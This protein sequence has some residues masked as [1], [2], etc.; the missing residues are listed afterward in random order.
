MRKIPAVFFA[1]LLAWPAALPAGEPVSANRNTKAQNPATALLTAAK[2]ASAGAGAVNLAPGTK[3]DA[4]WNKAIW[5]EPA[6]A[7]TADNIYRLAGAQNVGGGGAAGP[8]QGAGLK[9]DYPTTAVNLRGS[10]DVNLIGARHGGRV[11]ASGAGPIS[12]DGAIVVPAA[13]DNLALAVIDGSMSVRSKVSGSG[14]VNITASVPGPFLFV[15]D[16]S[17]FTGTF[18]LLP[19]ST[20]VDYQV[21]FTSSAPEGRLGIAPS[22]ANKGRA[23][24]QLKGNLR[25]AVVALPRA[26]GGVLYLP[27]G[28]YRY[29]DLAIAGADLACLADGG[30]EIEVLGMETGLAKRTALLLQGTT[31]NTLSLAGEWRFAL[32]AADAGIAEKWH[33][34]ALVD[35]IRLP[36]VLQSQ[37]FGHAISKTMPW[38]TNL[39]DPHWF[40]REMFK[41]HA[42]EGKVKIPYFSQPPRHY[43]G[44]AWYQRDIEIPPAWTGRSV[45]L[46]LELPHWQTDLWLDDQPVGFNKGLQAPHLYDLGMIPPGRH[47]LTV[48]VDNRRIFPLG[49]DSHSVSDQLGGTWNG[50]VGRIELQAVAACHFDTVNVHPH[51]AEKFVRVTAVLGNSSGLAGRG[52]LRAEATLRGAATPTAAKTVEVAWTRNGGSVEFDLPLGPDA[53]LWDEFNPNLY[54]LRLELK[55]ATGSLDQRTLTFGL[56]DFQVNGTRFAINGRPLSF[57]STQFR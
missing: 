5:G 32:D 56:R 26:G 35:R 20:A 4:A 49:H 28:R 39:N 19:A 27:N 45:G 7:P 11:C 2:K 46:L 16:A 18:C 22:E 53:R 33:L 55:D 9:L 41:P 29:R 6:A 50:I 47:V 30:G 51:A 25:F 52:L 10:A 24:L 21:I 14:T 48:R 57:R 36:G 12:L 8:F 1:L 43:L 54:E 38:I 40:E 13:E 17:A 31:G 23:I 44:A 15:G 37:G 34:Q 42:R 3:P